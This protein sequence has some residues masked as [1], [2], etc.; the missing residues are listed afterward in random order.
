MAVLTRDVQIPIKG[1]FIKHGIPC[2]GADTFYAGAI[3]YG[4]DTNGKCQAVPA[5]GDK[6]V[7]ICAE[8]VVATAADTIIPVYIWGLMLIPYASAA[9][10]DV[11][12]VCMMDISAAQTD[13]PADLVVGTVGAG[14]IGIGRVVSIEGSAGWVLVDVNLGVYVATAGWGG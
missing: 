10:A 1:P 11:G 3:L 12:E 6:F 7:G 4:D 2:V 14:D 13:N 5:S 8:Q 9:Q